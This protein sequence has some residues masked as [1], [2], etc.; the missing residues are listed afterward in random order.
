MKKSRDYQS[1]LRKISNYWIDSQKQLFKIL[2][3]FYILKSD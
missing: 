1:F 3:V 2:I